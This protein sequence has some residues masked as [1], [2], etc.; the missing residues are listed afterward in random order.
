M[1][2]WS[3]FRSRASFTPASTAGREGSKKW[4]A[5]SIFPAGEGRANGTGNSHGAQHAQRIRSED[6][7]PRD[8]PSPRRPRRLLR[9]YRQTGEFPREPFPVQSRSLSREAPD[10]SPFECAP[11]ERREPKP[12]R[13]SFKIQ[14]RLLFTP[15]ILTSTRCS[16]RSST[17]DMDPS[18]R[19]TPSTVTMIPS[20]AECI[21][22]TVM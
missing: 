6:A 13:F 5:A 21:C 8:R 19:S 12:L 4:V 2:S 3:A 14:F 17:R 11:E 1:I 15:G 7:S 16:L 18:F 20:V 22:R 9:Q 10:P